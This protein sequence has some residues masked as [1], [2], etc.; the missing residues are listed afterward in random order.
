[1]SEPNILTNVQ[2]ILTLMEEH[3]IRDACNLEAKKVF[4]IAKVINAEN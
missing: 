4:S 1:M 2:H 3:A